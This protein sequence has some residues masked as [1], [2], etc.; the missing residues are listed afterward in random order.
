VEQ[1]EPDSVSN[2]IILR[3]GHCHNHGRLPGRDPIYLPSFVTPK[4]HLLAISAA[5]VNF[6]WQRNPSP[7]WIILRVQFGAKDIQ[8]RSDVE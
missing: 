6:D 5:L 7:G 3:D 2:S 4:K 8:R 1:A